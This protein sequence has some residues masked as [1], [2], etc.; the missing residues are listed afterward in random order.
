MK[1][2]GFYTSHSYMTDIRAR[3][4]VPSRFTIRLTGTYNRITRQGTVN[5]WVKNTGTTSYSG[6]IQFVIVEDSTYYSGYYQNQAMRDMIPDANGEA[7]TIV[8]N[9]SVLKTRNFTIAS[10]WP[11]D[12]CK[13]VAFVQ[14]TRAG[15]DT[16]QQGADLRIKAMLAVEEEAIGSVYPQC[17]ELQLHSSNPF[18]NFIDIGY[19]IPI[20]ERITLKIYSPTGRLVKTIADGLAC[21][22]YHTA[23]FNAGNLPSGVYL[24]MLKDKDTIITQKIT[25]VK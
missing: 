12:S 25:L 2:E 19:M 10:S 4:I 8:A 11:Q 15:G 23:R 6:V 1:L 14:N 24:V 5:A 21:H 22:G 16:I 18:S 13:I 7:I 3:T 17:I 20:D 9:D